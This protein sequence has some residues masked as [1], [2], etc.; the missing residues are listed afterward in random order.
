VFSPGSAKELGEIVAWAAAEETPLEV[1][2]GGSKR[3]IGR[4][5]QVEHA[6]G[7]GRLTGIAAYEPAELVLTAASGTPLAE[8]EAVLEA[9]NQM[10][11][12]EP[13]DWRRLLGAEGAAQTIGGVLACDLSGPRRIKAG[14]ARDH[15]LGFQAVN[16]QG[17]AFKSGG[18][19]VKNVTG[20]DLAKLMAG[21][22]GTLGVLTEVNLKVLPRPEVTRTVL[23]TGL[24]D[25]AAVGTLTKAL[26]SP[27]DVS[28]AAH[29][30]AGLAGSSAVAEIAGAGRAVTALRVEGPEPSVVHRCLELREMLGASGELGPDGSAQFWREIGNASL[31]AKPRDRAVW[32][33]SAAPS[34]GPA[35]GEVIGRQLAGEFFYDWGGGLIWASVAAAEDCGAAVLRAAVAAQ[36]GGHATLI[37]APEGAR[38]MVDVFEPL[39][40]ALAALSARVKESFDPHRIFNPGRMYAGI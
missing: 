1:I 28:G 30:P 13:V 37:R 4:A 35:I 9:G 32:R 39:A 25:V 34:A 6:V 38:A 36:G 7:L 31:V 8:I 14:A 40:P 10:L 18:K 16:G 20:Y 11:A 29:L 23:L 21:S 15:F 19:V 5:V 27:H 2:G 26:N 17:E 3:A 33:I 12:F 24:G 22:F